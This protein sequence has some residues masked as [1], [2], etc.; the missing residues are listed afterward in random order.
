MDPLIERLQVEFA[1]RQAKNRKYSLRA[2]ARDLD[3]NLTSVSMMLKRQRSPS[4]ETRKKLVRIMAL[5]PAYERTVG[6]WPFS[7]GFLQDDQFKMTSEWVHWAI[8]N[9]VRPGAQPK[10]H[11]AIQKRLEIPHSVLATALDRLLRLGLICRSGKYFS[12][13]IDQVRTSDDVPTTAFRRL[14]AEVMDV[15][16]DA[17][18][19]VAVEK[20]EFSTSFMMIH[21]SRVPRI[22]ELIRKFRNE[23]SEVFDPKVE[24]DKGTKLHVIAIQFFPIEKG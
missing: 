23:M 13:T 16:K 4:P 12:R 18:S 10:T 21:P 1:D 7:D 24:T 5:S 20:R 22:K 6:D 15:A 14:H 17:L 19:E 2:F 9:L 8:L 11:E 3:L